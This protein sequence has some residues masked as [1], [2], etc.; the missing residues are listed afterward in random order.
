MGRCVKV[1]GVCNCSAQLGSAET[2]A[3]TNSLSLSITCS[4]MLQQY[5][6]IFLSIH[7]CYVELSYIWA[8]CLMSSL[9]LNSCAPY[10]SILYRTM[11]HVVC[12]REQDNIENSPGWHY[13][14][15]HCHQDLGWV[16]GRRNW[17][18]R[19]EWIAWNLMRIRK[20]SSSWRNAS[21]FN[22]NKAVEEQRQRITFCFFKTRKL[23]LKQHGDETQVN[24][25]PLKI[26]ILFPK[27][28][29]YNV[30]CLL[31]FKF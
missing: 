10:V 14:W 31:G 13:I 17:E 25:F 29:E 26:Y 21:W 28:I 4:I 30:C 20:E 9:I 11:R 24:W 2:C 3:Q 6:E 16:S 1:C 23:I 15:K 7:L 27:N 18:E 22:F 12:A 19:G 5:L 8:Y